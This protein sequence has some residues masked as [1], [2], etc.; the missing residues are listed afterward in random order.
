MKFN[1]LEFANSAYRH[2]LINSHML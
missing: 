1:L 2:T